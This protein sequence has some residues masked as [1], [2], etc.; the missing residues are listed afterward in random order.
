[1][2]KILVIISFLLTQ[3]KAENYG[4]VLAGSTHVFWK[5][6]MK[7]IESVKKQSPEVL[8]VDRSPLDD[9]NQVVENEAQ[10]KMLSYM[11]DF[12]LKGLIL[13]PIPTMKSKK[14]KLKFPTVFVDRDSSDFD[15]AIAVVSTDN[16]FAGRVA[17]RTIASRIKKHSSFGVMGLS[18]NV[19]TTSEREKGF[20]EEA[21]KLGLRFQFYEY[22]GHGH[23]EAQAKVTSVLKTHKN[24]DVIFTS[25]ESTTRGA[26]NALSSYSTV[27]KPKLIGFDFRD[28][29]ESAIRNKTIDVLVVQDPYEM[30]AVALK[31]VMDFANG[32]KI[33][34]R[35]FISPLVVTL[36]NVQSAAIQ[37]KLKQFK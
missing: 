12:H 1:M 33:K 4:V 36:D 13:A 7:G 21:I 15:S 10:L 26:M 6:V 5:A 35:I 2:F 37:N 20:K 29:F 18:P 32:K 28:E 19:S 8:I 14:I 22:L 25:N 9:D 30:G 34:K 31:T 3:A 16:Y 23:R 11:D 17:A 27:R 24:I